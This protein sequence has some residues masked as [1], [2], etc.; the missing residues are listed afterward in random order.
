MGGL[1]NQMFQFAFGKY[2]AIKNNTELKFDLNFLL[3]RS[4]KTNP[5]FVNRDYDLSIFNIN[6]S[7]ASKEE[8]KKLKNRTDSLIADKIANKL[9]GNKKS[10]FKE[11]EFHF[12]EDHLKISDNSYIE[13]YWQSEK[14]FL[15]IS[16]ELRNHYFTFK[17]PLSEKSEILSTKIKQSNS[18][19][20]NV[21]RGDFVTNPVHGTMGIEYYSEGEEILLFKY[22]DLEMFVFSDEIDWCRK[23][24][25]FKSSVTFVSHEYAG[26]KFQDY[27]RLMSTCKQFIIPNSS[28]AW[29]AVWLCLN[30]DKTVIAPKKWFNYEAWNTID[31]I[32]QTW[33]RL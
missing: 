22:K 10:Y 28:F 27:L 33:I 26:E 3:D 29:W 21:R 13:G 14:Y 23:N 15:A 9:L 20:I 1:G 5:T 32:P 7:I 31:L 4:P 6:E 18:V 11:N 24:L 16:N 2:L 8:I 17:S 19:C 25:K 30:P 12:S